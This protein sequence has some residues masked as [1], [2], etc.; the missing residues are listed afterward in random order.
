M[1]PRTSVVIP[2]GSFKSPVTV[3]TT[4]FEIVR[5][6]LVPIS[7]IKNALVRSLNVIDTGYANVADVLYP[8]VLEYTPVPAN[9]DTIPPDVHTRILLFEISVMYMLL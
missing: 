7:V 9:V 6:V 8:S 2:A 4:L 5:I 1:F 3:V